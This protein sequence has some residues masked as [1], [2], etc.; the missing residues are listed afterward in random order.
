[1]TMYLLILTGVGTGAFA[2]GFLARHFWPVHVHAFLPVKATAVRSVFEG[3]VPG[4]SQTAVLR[5]C[6]CGETDTRTLPGIWSLQD[7]TSIAALRRT[8]SEA[9][10]DA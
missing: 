2:C 7:L 9:A 8:R 4:V 5:L 3:M 6:K 1:M 10:Q